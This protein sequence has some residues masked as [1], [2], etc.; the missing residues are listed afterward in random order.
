[1][2]KIESRPLRPYPKPILPEILEGRRMYDGD[3]GETTYV[4][5]E[6]YRP[7]VF[8][9]NVLVNGTGFTRQVEIAGI[10]HRTGLNF[11]E[12]FDNKTAKVSPIPEDEREIALAAVKQHLVRLGRD[13]D[14]IGF[15]S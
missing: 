9:H 8:S 2:N 6:N 12:R 14:S 13:Y 5:G 11:E 4:V 7:V 1:M 3:T 15:G 10:V